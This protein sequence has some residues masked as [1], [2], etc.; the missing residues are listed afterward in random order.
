M[1]PTLSLPVRAASASGN[2]V[3]IAAAEVAHRGVGV[4]QRRC[5]ALAQPV[6]ALRYWLASA[7]R[8]LAIAL[9]IGH[10]E[11]HFLEDVV[12]VLTALSLALACASISASENCTLALITEP[13]H[14]AP[15]DVALSRSRR[16]WM[17]TPLL[18]RTCSRLLS[19]DLEL[20][21]D[22]QHGV[23]DVG[24]GDGEAEPRGLLHLQR[25]VDQFVDRRLLVAAVLELHQGQALRDLHVGDRLAIDR[26]LTG[27]P[28]PAGSG[29][30]SSARAN[31]ECAQNAKH[32]H[33]LPSLLQSPRPSV[34]EN[35]GC[36]KADLH[37]PAP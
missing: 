15:G 6:K 29:S 33:H 18:V 16:V 36:Q 28:P 20:L 3:G 21:R 5:T 7:V 1:P 17:P 26:D 35:Y 9:A 22:L 13:R 25:L 10:Q 34:V 24:V 27:S 4:A 31:T 30:A 2:C 14:L 32:L 19:R 23:V 12:E 11:Q 8:L 37:G